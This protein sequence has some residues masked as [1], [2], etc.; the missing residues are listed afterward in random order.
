MTR[1]ANG[2]FG[3]PALAGFVTPAATGGAMSK[4]RIRARMEITGETYQQALVSI[5]KGITLAPDVQARIDAL[6]EIMKQRNRDAALKAEDNK[7]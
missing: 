3:R 6:D 2:L 4:R 5:R 7:S 1:K